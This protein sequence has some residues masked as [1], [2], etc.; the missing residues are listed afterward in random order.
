MSAE[1]YS[2]NE[3]GGNN[4]SLQYTTVGGSKPLHR[5][6]KCQPK[7]IGIIVLI[8]G[9]SFFLIT[10]IL[11]EYNFGS[12]WSV[13]PPGFI[14]GVMFIVCGI[15][16]ILT[17]YNTTKKT[18][19]VSLAL[20]IVTILGSCWTILHMLPNLAHRSYYRDYEFIEENAT[21]IPEL[22]W[23]SEAMIFAV[24]LLF[25]IYGVVGVIIFIVMSCLAVAALRSTKSQAIVVMTTTP[26]EPPVE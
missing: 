14:L 22:K 13:I 23:S 8:L 1:L 3:P 11:P 21:E 15:L 16:Y 24:E 20:S 2:A 4:A 5:F 12:R 19:T 9:S 10:A 26:A 17:E 18:V 6:I 25:F 7:I